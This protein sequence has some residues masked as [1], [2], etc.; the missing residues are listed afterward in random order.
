MGFEPDIFQLRK[1]SYGW[2]M[3]KDKHSSYIVKTPD[4]RRD[5]KI[6]KNG[7]QRRFCQSFRI[8]QTR[9]PLHEIRYLRI[10]RKSVEKM[11]VSLKYDNNNGYFT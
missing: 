8:E 3:N 1:R 7:Y 4:F 11:Q 6:K 9:L 2:S 10:F 5:C